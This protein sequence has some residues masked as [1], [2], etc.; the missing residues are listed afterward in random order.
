MLDDGEL[1][2]DIQP[3]LAVSKHSAT[4]DILLTGGTGFVGAYL[5]HSLL[6]MTDRPIVALVRSSSPSA[7]RARLIAALKKSNVPFH[8]GSNG[9]DLAKMVERRVQVVCGDLTEKRLGM[10]QDIWDDLASKVETVYHCGAEVDYIKSYGAL[11]GPNVHGCE[12]VIRLCA[13]GTLKRLNLI[14]TTFVAGWTATTVLDES[15]CEPPE[16]ALNFGYAQSKWVAERLAYQ[17]M[18]RG[19]PVKVFRPSLLT[20]S[21]TGSFVRE[22][23]ASRFF[24]YLVR[25]GLRPTCMNQLSLIPADIAARNMI[26]VS[27]HDETSNGT[28]HVTADDYYNMM[29]AC[30]CITRRY[31]FEMNECSLEELVDHVNEHCNRED[32]LFPLVPFIN[33]NFNRLS[34]MAEKR[35][36]TAN[37]QS[38][39]QLAPGTCPAP[40][41]EHTM[42]LLVDYLRESD[43]I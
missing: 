9:R 28:F 41:L 26:A 18:R 32:P 23:L 12:Q 22:D 29:D 37:F 7:G 38:A 5:L 13:T 11:T 19:L 43:M 1:A 8:T 39:V 21:T 42:R 31:G 36:S 10:A 35:Y 24:S 27:L 25:F 2:M 34:D 15:E 16:G 33:R 6:M 4:R 20:A 40:S 14:S 17:A 3:G 30:D